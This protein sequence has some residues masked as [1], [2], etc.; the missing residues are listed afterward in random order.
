MA[1]LVNLRGFLTWDVSV[2]NAESVTKF[3][4]N[5]RHW[6]RVVRAGLAQ[7]HF[8]VFH[9]VFLAIGRKNTNSLDPHQKSFIFALFAAIGVAFQ[10]L[11]EFI[12]CFVLVTQITLQ[13]QVV[14]LLALD[15]PEFCSMHIIQIQGR[16]WAILVNPKQLRC[17]RRNDVVILGT[18]GRG[19]SRF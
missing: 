15:A 7:T 18:I 14:A 8:I 3:V 5:D 10:L 13:V 12:L 17:T 11:T 1:G 9:T 16:P 4:Q 6:E 19:K 2:G